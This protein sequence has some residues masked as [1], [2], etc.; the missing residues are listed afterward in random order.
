MLEIDVGKITFIITKSRE[1]E[2]QTPGPAPD[3]IAEEGFGGRLAA[4][5]F[6]ETPDVDR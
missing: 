4:A 5:E 1:F 3:G 6:R 2:A